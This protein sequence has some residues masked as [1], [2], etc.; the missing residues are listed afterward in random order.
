M[1]E[2]M[3]TTPED[4]SNI[5]ELIIAVDLDPT[6]PME[7]LN[8]KDVKVGEP[9]EEGTGGEDWKDLTM[10]LLMGTPAAGVTSDDIS[11]EEAV[12]AVS[13]A[14]EGKEMDEAPDF[15]SKAGK[16]GEDAPVAPFGPK[17]GGGMRMAL[18][19]ALGNRKEDDE[20]EE[21]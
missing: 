19:R 12:E 11:Y 18:D 14:L 17:G 15:F 4:M 16:A 9:G 3:A 6:D 21:F 20:E 7:P 13:R 1:A 2:D 10:Q 5:V 8:V